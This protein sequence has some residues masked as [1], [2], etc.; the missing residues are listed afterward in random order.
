[1]GYFGMIL[2]G[3]FYVAVGICSSA[4]T[5][6]QLVAALIGIAL[7]GLLTRVVDYLAG[8]Q[9]GGWRV[10]LSHVN[11]LHRF[12]DFSKGI[13]DTQSL[14]FFLSAT[15]FFLFLAVKVLESRRWR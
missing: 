3:A 6:Y 12:D 5:K 13:F 8:L 10:A 15:I 9:G 14:I 7:L 11:V 4:L 2:L 1:L